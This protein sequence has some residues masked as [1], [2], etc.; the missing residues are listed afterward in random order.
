M[1]LYDN[2]LTS[3]GGLG[4]ALVSLNRTFAFTRIHLIDSFWVFNKEYTL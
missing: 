3:H 4:S 2:I 1:L